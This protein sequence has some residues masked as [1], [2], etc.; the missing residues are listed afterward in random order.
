M[1]SD[2][3]GGIKLTIP[4]F[5]SL[6]SQCFKNEVDLVLL[7][8][9]PAFRDRDR[10]SSVLLAVGGHSLSLKR[11]MAVTSATDKIKLKLHDLTRTAW[12]HRLVTVR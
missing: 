2:L 4:F 6:F 3:N 9:T 10:P 8:L 5:C 7:L 1:C 12:G 11:R